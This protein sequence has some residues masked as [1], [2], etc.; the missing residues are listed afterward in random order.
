MGRNCFLCGRKPS[1]E[2]SLSL[3]KFPKEEAQCEKWREACK[4]TKVDDVSRIHIC[5]LHFAKDD[6]QVFTV[7]G[8]P[9]AERVRKAVPS[10]LLPK[11]PFAPIVIPTQKCDANQVK[12]NILTRITD[13][14][15]ASNETISENDSLRKSPESNR[16]LKSTTIRLLN[17]K[18]P[19]ISAVVNGSSVNPTIISDNETLNNDSMDSQI[20]SQEKET[21]HNYSKPIITEIV[22]EESYDQCQ[23]TEFSDCGIEPILDDSRSSPFEEFSPTAVETT[24]IYETPPNTKKRRCF[25]PRFVSEIAES[26]LSTP[27]G[28][29]RTL[30]MIK[31]IDRKKSLRIRKLMA[32]TRYM[33][34]RIE[35]LEDML[36]SYLTQ[37]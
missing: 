4:L 34:K 14:A 35:T 26:D 23:P 15:A 10:I 28:R 7:R 31:E 27:S 22:E 30:L 19:L 36:E 21:E 16:Q 17:P 1:S 8:I 32:R 24:D 2:K 12:E 9:K 37:G 29:R 11:K 13:S 33:Q 3:H 20:D 6:L 18:K 5:S 25:D